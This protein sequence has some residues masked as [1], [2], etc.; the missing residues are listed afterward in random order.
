MST[1]SGSTFPFRQDNLKSQLED[2]VL[3][4]WPCQPAWCLLWTTMLFWL[5]TLKSSKAAV[6]IH[7]YLITKNITVPALGHS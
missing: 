6:S 1:L 7:K 2:Q 3:N 5:L 4:S